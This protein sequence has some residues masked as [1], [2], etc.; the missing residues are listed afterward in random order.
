MGKLLRL[1]LL[2]LTSLQTMLGY[3]D[4]T[5]K[6]RTYVHKWNVTP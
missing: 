4:A 1:K 6:L 2:V 5:F 3:S